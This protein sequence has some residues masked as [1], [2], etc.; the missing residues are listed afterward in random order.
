[1]LAPYQLLRRNRKTLARR[2][3]RTNRKQVHRF[4]GV[5]TL[6]THCLYCAFRPSLDQAR[7]VWD[8]ID[9]LEPDDDRVEPE[10]YHV[11]L[12]SLG[13]WPNSPTGRIERAR[14][15]CATLEGPSFRIVL[16][17][18]V[19]ADRVLLK[20][21]ETIPALD[22][23]QFRLRSVLADA[24][25]VSCRNASFNP[26]LTVSYRAKPGVPAFVPPVSWLV[27]DFV[28]IESLFGQRT[29]TDRG[30]WLLGSAVDHKST[31]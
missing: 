29:Q 12:V 21:S 30:R 28:L 15:V 22:R 31:Y 23:F 27:Q 24:G 20:P 8:Q 6:S 25:L 7:Y 5:A 16:D 1:M 19:L 3:D 2:Q 4:A 10:R 14:R 18:L 11:T 9:W 17:H 13:N 26:H